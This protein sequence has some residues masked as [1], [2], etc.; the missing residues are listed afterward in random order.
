MFQLHLLYDQSFPSHF[1]WRSETFIR[2]LHRGDFSN[3][4]NEGVF[5][6]L[7]CKLHFPFNVWIVSSGELRVK[8]LSIY[9]SY[10]PCPYFC[11]CRWTDGAKYIPPSLSEIL[12][13]FFWKIFRK[14][15][16]ILFLVMGQDQHLI[17]T[18]KS[19]FLAFTFPPIQSRS[20]DW[21]S[22]RCMFCGLWDQQDATQK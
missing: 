10:I 14:K 1:E 9:F 13:S 2:T 16:K 22:W 21:V 7:F 8:I 3:S 4:S 19:V 5:P 17:I 20:I 12:L 6:E 11:H 15:K 18:L